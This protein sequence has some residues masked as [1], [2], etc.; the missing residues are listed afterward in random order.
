MPKRKHAKE[1]DFWNKDGMYIVPYG[2]KSFKE[3]TND[4]PDIKVIFIKHCTP[5]SVCKELSNPREIETK[6]NYFIVDEEEMTLEICSKI[7]KF[8]I[9][10]RGKE[11]VWNG[12]NFIHR[13]TI[14]CEECFKIGKLTPQKG[15]L[16]HIPKCKHNGKKLQSND[17]AYC[18]ARSFASFWDDVV[19]QIAITKLPQNLHL[20]YKSS[21]KKCDFVCRVCQH[22]FSCS[23]DHVVCQGNWCPYCASKKLC[24][25]ENCISCFNKSFASF[26]SIKRNCI[27]TIEN[28]LLI[29]KHSNKKYDF[30]CYVCHHLFSC[31]LSNMCEGNWCPYCANQSLCEKENCQLCFT[32]SFASF[33]S[34]KRNCIQ[35]NDNLLSIFKNANKKYDFVCYM[36]YHM[37]SSLLNSISQGSWCPYCANQ[38]LCGKENCKICFDKSFASFD[39]V[40]RNCI[41]TNE[42]LLLIF[43]H[44]K[45]KYDFLC[46]TCNH[47]FSARLNDILNG[48][49]CPYCSNR[50][51][52]GKDNCKLCFDKSFASFD[53]LKRNCIQTNENL[54]L[55]FKYSNKKHDFICHVCQHL[56]VSSLDH[57]SF[58]EWCRYC[59]GHVCGQSDCLICEKQCQM[60]T[61]YKKARKQTKVT[62][63]WY[64][65]EHFQ[66]CINRNPKETPLIYRAKIT[67][68]IY[69]LAELQRICM[70]SDD[71]YYWSNPTSW[72]CKMIPGLTYKPD[73]L[74]CFDKNLQLIPY[75]NDLTLNLNQ[76]GYVIIFEVLEE[77]RKQHSLA[78]SISDVDREAN[79]R[80]LLDVYNIPLGCLYA[81]MA[82]IK[83]F[84]AHPDDV[85]FHKLLNGEYEVIPNKLEV[86][87]TRIKDIKDTLSFMFENSFNGTKWIGH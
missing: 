80:N 25:E 65:N 82:H 43:Q 67:L 46:C 20:L 78:R 12:V 68:E 63:L 1:L 57:V 40:K 30:L 8:K 54:L 56:F 29:F 87:Q 7:R 4:T 36:C 52:C 9:K 35:T 84:T 17:C 72:D 19:S 21:K 48:R 85:F 28:L 3:L 39:G 73:N 6:S 79:I 22:L 44:T 66:D 83:H 16:I 14:I 59:Q 47:L 86:F 45:K 32:K 69:T 71:C 41:R 27:Q 70:F 81:S 2:N 38:K 62:K 13:S 23:L 31:S 37:F 58:G 26:D 60:G 5:M 64:C 74:F 34:A 55:I 24:G 11:I 61:C 18:F 51:L 75:A 10:I 15:C 53:P 76:I 42:N 50:T 49:W 77:G 33:D